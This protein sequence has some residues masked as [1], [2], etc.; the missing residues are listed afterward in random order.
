MFVKILHTTLQTL[1]FELSMCEMLIVILT[2]V[3][4]VAAVPVIKKQR[5]PGV[6]PKMGKNGKV[7]FLLKLTDAPKNKMREANWGSTERKS[8]F[9]IRCLT[10]KYCSPTSIRWLLF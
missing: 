6:G 2:S 7:A 9:T 8:S 10:N 3:L 4:H 1:K 5:D